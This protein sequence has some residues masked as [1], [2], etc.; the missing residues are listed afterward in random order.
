MVPKGE[1]AEEEP[2]ELPTPTSWEQGCCSSLEPEARGLGDFKY[3]TQPVWGWRGGA[4]G[5]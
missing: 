2:A 4:G 3:F 1:E 5:S